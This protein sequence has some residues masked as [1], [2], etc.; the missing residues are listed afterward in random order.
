MDDGDRFDG[1][2]SSERLLNGLRLN[3]FSPCRVDANRFAAAAVDNGRQPCSKDAV[4][5]DDDGISRLN[6]ID[7]RR[8]HA[9]RPGPRK[10]NR[11][12]VFG[13]KHYAQGG[14]NVVHDAQKDGIEVADERRRKRPQDA[15]MYETRSWTQEEA[16]WRREFVKGHGVRGRLRTVHCP[17][18]QYSGVLPLPAS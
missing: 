14:L 6:E 18:G 13:L 15:R 2:R 9:G 12:R 16:A 1:A 8:F 7:D 17:A 5:A 4:H 10:G 3:G 11:E